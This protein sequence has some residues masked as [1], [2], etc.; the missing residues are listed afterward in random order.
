MIGVERTDI[1]SKAKAIKSS[2]VKGVAGRNMVTAV[3]VKSRSGEVEWV[4][5]GRGPAPSRRGGRGSRRPIHRRPFL[6]SSEEGS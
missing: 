2:T 6:S 1:K 3:K 4:R 5:E